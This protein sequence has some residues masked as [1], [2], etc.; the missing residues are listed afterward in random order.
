MNA[1]NPGLRAR[2]SAPLMPQGDLADGD[3]LDFTGMA[4]TLWRG[5]WRLL[6][7]VLIATG[8]GGYWATELAIPQFRATSVVV[9]D[10]QQEPVVDLGSVVPSLGSDTSVVN[11]EVEVLRS[12]SLTAKVVQKLDLATDPEFSPW[13]RTPGPVGRLRLT[14]AARL[15]LPAG[16]PNI[17]MPHSA[18]ENI[19]VDLMADHISIRNIPDSLVFEITA[20]TSG[21]LKSANIANALAE[22]YVFGQIETK[23]TATEQATKWLTGRVAELK[24]A[25]EE[26]EAKTKEFATQIDLVDAQALDALSRQLKNLRERVQYKSSTQQ[27][28]KEKY[29]ALTTARTRFE[30]QLAAQDSILSGLYENVRS[31]A[32]KSRF[33]AELRR[34]KGRIAS[35]LARTDAQLAALQQSEGDLNAR[36]DAQSADLVTLEQLTRDAEASRLIYEYFLSRLKETSVQQGVQQ[37]DSRVLSSAVVP[38]APATPRLPL[39]LAMS[40][41]IGLLA[42]TTL[43]L[44]KEAKQNTFRNAE[45]LESETGIT[46]M[47]QIPLIP[48]GRRAGVLNYLSAKPT[49]AAAEAVRNLRTSIQLSNIENPPQVIMSTSSVPNEGKTTHSLALAQNMAAMG[50]S[51]LVIEGDIRRRVFSAYFKIGEKPGLLSVLSDSAALK[52]VVWHHPTFAFDILIGEQSDK[53]A[54]DVYASDEFADFIG[55]AR[56]QYEVIVIDTPPVLAVPDARLIGQS[57][58]AII[59]SVRW[60]K[61]SK[62]FV[63]RGLRALDAVGLRPKGLVLGQI[64]QVKFRSYGYGDGYEVQG[65]YDN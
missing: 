8:I 14:V 63:D 47:G 24:S 10:P 45:D 3:L 44:G 4:A 50:K 54:A 28:L 30:Q 35:D 33:D 61:T 52:D 16:I 34:L 39:V 5:K 31:N 12:R 62:L 11:T 37:A 20:Q 32:G 7:M 19:T 64:N 58:D 42:G 9:L 29:Q 18:R 49:S 25:L 38:D 59:Y 43:V 17:P 40:A 48:R 56:N 1:P 55:R 15:G 23:F 27:D 21:P 36:I 26:A 22:L 2:I 65:Y 13:L 60:D 41:A 57:V 6:F 51:V 53:N 46:V